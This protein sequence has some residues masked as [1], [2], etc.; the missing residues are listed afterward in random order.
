MPRHAE[1]AGLPW[2]APALSRCRTASALALALAITTP[3]VVGLQDAAAGQDTAIENADRGGGGDGDPADTAAAN[4]AEAAADDPTVS[5]GDRDDAA[6]AES[7]WPAIRIPEWDAVFVRPRGWTGAASAFSV[8]TQDG[9]MLWLFG[10]T[11]I[12][13]VENGQRVAAT[14]TLVAN[15]AAQHPK[16][17][18][19]LVDLR[20]ERHADAAAAIARLDEQ[21]LDTLDPSLRARVIRSGIVAPPTPLF[22][23]F[24]AGQDLVRNVP[25]AW[26]SPDPLPLR[27]NAPMSGEEGR[28]FGWYVPTAGLIT[29]GQRRDDRLV[30]FMRQM[31][32]PFPFQRESN[33]MQLRMT[34]QTRGPAPDRVQSVGDALILIERPHHTPIGE[35]LKVQ[36]P[37]RLTIGELQ[38]AFDINQ[39]LMHWGDAAIFETADPDE[40]TRPIG[41][42]FVFVFGVRRPVTGP[43]ELHIARA[44]GGAADWF[45]TWRYWNPLETGP[46][47]WSPRVQEGQPILVGAIPEEFTVIRLPI[48]GEVVY[49]MISNEP[50]WGPHLQMRFA[51]TLTGPWS[52][53]VNVFRPD[54]VDSDP[55]YFVRSVA[56]HPGLSGSGSL[57][58]SYVIDSRDLSERTR[59]EILRP[60][61]I[62]IPV[63]QVAAR[64]L[65][66]LPAAE[67]DG[68]GEGGN[69]ASDQ[70]G[71]TAPAERESAGGPSDQRFP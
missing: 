62:A 69:A 21:P 36:V 6:L 8:D 46:R 15:S 5:A 44:P 30:L 45:H 35:W 39:P 33:R 11:W 29:P 38:A 25:E 54:E 2:W 34:T 14:G 1:P 10:P 31:G 60:R 18:Q 66:S 28:P 67:G 61:F 17:R 50:G 20:E 40:P 9:R 42:G 19:P 51:R 4:E 12:G 41:G 24:F 71:G 57:M 26:L 70:P 58:L 47:Q 16:P 56:A 3:V 59:T 13:P 49:A 65:A 37:N 48:R 43:A 53:P 52:E 64:G 7:P 23:E 22:T 68:P 63:E 27:Q 32:V 55:D